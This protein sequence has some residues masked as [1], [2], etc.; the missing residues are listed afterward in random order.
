[1]RFNKSTGL[2]QSEKE[3]TNLCDHSFLSLWSYPNLFRKPAKEL[4]DLLV[5]FGDDVL[6]FSDKSCAYPETGDPLLDWRRWYRRSI[7]K[8]VHQIRRAEGWLRNQ[9]DRVFLDARCTQ[10][11]PIR[12]PPSDRIRFHRACIALGAT[13][14]AETETGKRSITVSAIDGGDAK[15]FTMGSN[16]IM[17]GFVHVFDENTLPVILSELSTA[18]DVFD[19]LRKKETLFAEGQFAFAESE[20]DLLGY[21]LWNNREFP[22]PKITPFRLESNLW[23]QVEANECFLAARE[24]NKISYFWDGLIE[25]L[26]EHYMKEQLEYGNEMAVVEY[27]QVVLIMAAEGRFSRR[28]LSNWILKRAERAK[29]VY[30]G[31]IFPSLQEEVLY[32]LLVGPGDDGQ[33][34]AKYREARMQQLHLRCIAAKAAQQDR[35][36]I[37][38]IALDA[39]GVKGSSEDFIAMDTCGWT[40]KDIEKAEQTRQELG[41]FVEGKVKEARLSESEYPGT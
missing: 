8:S 5:I 11:L 35:R 33:N 22:A 10:P 34:H 12:I 7:T 13:A 24:E 20:L 28:L 1:M 15:P 36:F 39:R 25:Y 31:S 32:V 6:I 19:Y 9:P 2:T 27:E 23:Q 30:I 29:N 17:E 3:L 18:P 40:E 4:C 14:R 21:Y 38:G 26:T 37:I 16:T 41:F